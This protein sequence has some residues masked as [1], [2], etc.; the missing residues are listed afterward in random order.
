MDKEKKI[1][2]GGQ[3]VME[4]VMMKG[5]DAIGIAVRRPSGEIVVSYEKIERKIENP[6]L[7]LPFIRGMVNFV[8][9]MLMGMK[10]LEKSTNMLG[11]VEDEPSRFEKWLR[12]TFGKS[13]DKV[14]MSTAV[15]LALA[16]SI[17][18][19]FMIPEGLAILLRNAGYSNLII[20]LGSGALRICILI[21]YMYAISFVPDIKRTFMYHGAEHKTVYCHENDLELTPENAQ[22]FSRLHPRCGTSFILIVFL[23]SIILFS[24]IGYHGENYLYRLFSRL[25]LMPIIAGISYEILKALAH[26]Q[27]RI[28]KI[29]RYPGLQ[30]QNL[31]TREP[32][33]QMLE[34]AIV[35]MNTALYGLPKT[36]NNENGYAIVHSFRESEPAYTSET[37]VLDENSEQ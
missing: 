14:V 3:A 1:D 27:S 36:E 5:P 20:D 15:V 23:T 32:D 6:F 28:A 34:C 11:T 17:L 30:L 22:N 24:L 21:L 37:M 10:V 12:K 25:L 33:L 26:S 19:F 13:I 35:A 4:G 2:I 8:S 29:L 7:K 31:S 9:M 16:F 18:L